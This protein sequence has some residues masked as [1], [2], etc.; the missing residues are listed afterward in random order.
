MHVNMTKVISLSDEAYG[1]LKKIKQNKSF[2]EIILEITTEKT[3][4][5]FASSIGTWNEDFAEDL[6]KKT[7]NERKKLKSKRFE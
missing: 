4:D 5:K 7:Y 3:N 6:K 2:S 1:R